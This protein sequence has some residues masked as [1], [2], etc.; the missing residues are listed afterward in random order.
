MLLTPNEDF[1]RN[2][3]FWTKETP[4]AESLF[5]VDVSLRV[6][7][8]LFSLLERMYSYLLLKTSPK[9]KHFK[10][11]I[12]CFTE[13]QKDFTL[14]AHNWNP[15]LEEMPGTHPATGLGNL[16][17]WVL[18]VS[19]GCLGLLRLFQSSCYITALYQ[20]QQNCGGTVVPPPCP[21]GAS[22]CPQSNRVQTAK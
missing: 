15:L 21:T 16:C 18:P 10:Q 13:K 4:A 8:Q 22:C 2:S 14:Y 3:G 6:C 11:S 20:F 5:C 19:E 12:L 17:P 7:I 9:P 1:H